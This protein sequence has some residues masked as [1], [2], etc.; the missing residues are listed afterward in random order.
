MFTNNIY[1]IKTKKK[2][3]KPNNTRTMPYCLHTLCYQ[4]YLLLK[5]VTP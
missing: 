3:I 4:F 5:L 2:L 1:S